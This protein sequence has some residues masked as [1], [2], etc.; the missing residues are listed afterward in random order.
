MMKPRFQFRLK[1][2]MLAVAIV[3]APMLLLSP[4]PKRNTP[5]MEL[6]GNVLI[7]RDGSIE[8]QGGSVRVG[9]DGQRT[10]IRASRIVVKN[11]GTTEVF[12]PGTILQGVRGDFR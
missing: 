3:A 2:L 11:D 12:G 6:I 4:A 10:E 8:V 9:Q 1:G 5:V 7:G